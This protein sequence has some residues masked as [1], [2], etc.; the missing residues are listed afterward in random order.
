M[1]MNKTIHQ[2]IIEISWYMR[3]YDKLH[4]LHCSLSYTNV[5]YLDMSHP[6]TDISSP[7][8]QIYTVACM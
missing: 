1:F 7:R 3:E 8:S 5:S 2:Q 4:A 6:Y